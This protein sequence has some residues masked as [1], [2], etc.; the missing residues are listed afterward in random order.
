MHDNAGLPRAA[1]KRRALAAESDAVSRLPAYRSPSTL[2]GRSVRFMDLSTTNGDLSEPQR[3]GY[4]ASIMGPRNR[5]LE[6]ENPALLASPFTDAG[7]M[8]NLKFPFAAARNRLLPGG[9]AREVTIR[10]KPI[11]V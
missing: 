7:T 3:D 11:I 1:L 4:G 9:W 6:R 10:E 5:A 8:P 2:C